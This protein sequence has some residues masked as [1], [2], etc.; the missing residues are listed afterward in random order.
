M[1][2]GRKTNW[3]KDRWLTYKTW[4][5]RHAQA[6]LWSSRIALAVAAMEDRRD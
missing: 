5:E 2:H 4:A 1:K 3:T 6:A